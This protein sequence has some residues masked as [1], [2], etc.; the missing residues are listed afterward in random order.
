MDYFDNRP[1]APTTKTRAEIEAEKATKPRPD[2]I[3][4]TALAAIGCALERAIEGDYA[5]GPLELLARGAH[6]RDIDTLADAWLAAAIMLSPGASFT[7]AVG[8]ALLVAGEVMGMGLIKHG[9]CT[10]RVAG[11]EQAEAQCHYASAVRHLAERLAGLEAD[12]DSGRDPLVHLLCQVPILIDLL[13]DPPELAGEN[14]GHA[15]M[16]APKVAR[17]P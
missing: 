12:R 3:P 4:A 9:P 11:T 10:W 8:K 15:M 5:G 7:V 13:A 14:D 1:K 2:L 16:P 6:A 17:L